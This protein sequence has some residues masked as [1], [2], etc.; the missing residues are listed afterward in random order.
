M[1]GVA[2]SKPRPLESG[3]SLEGFSC[4]LDIVDNWLHTR[5][6]GARAAGSAVV[7]VSYAA[8]KLAGFYT[9]SSQSMY[10]HDARGWLSRNVPQQIP[11]ILLGMLG[12][13]QSLQG[14]GLGRN[15]LLDASK[16]ACAV[17]GVIGAKALV[18]D[19]ATE[20]ARK[21]Y[22]SCGFRAIPGS[23]RMFAKLTS[24]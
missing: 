4:G 13:D 8:N 19:P 12:V 9:L 6:K 7:Y 18:V 20:T 10:R 2:F 24:S 14:M 21:L 17:S 16:R 11:I 1:G 3:D 5:A 22:E 23:T 15:L